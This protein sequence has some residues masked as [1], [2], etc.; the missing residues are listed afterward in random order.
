MITWSL[1]LYSPPGV[2][3][4]NMAVKVK[5]LWGMYIN[6]SIDR[7]P[8]VSQSQVSCLHNNIIIFNQ[9]KLIFRVM[10]FALVFQVFPLKCL[11]C[12][13]LPYAIPNQYFFS[14]S[15]VPGIALALWFPLVLTATH[16]SS[17]PSGYLKVRSTRP[18]LPSK[19]E[20]SVHEFSILKFLSS[21][22]FSSMASYLFVTFD[23]HQ[24]FVF[25]I[26]KLCDSSLLRCELVRHKW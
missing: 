17:S 21:H 20:K 2:S 4:C 22:N 7:I 13:N 3:S 14:F 8:K 19:L 16:S 18:G 25:N 9:F 23:F 10:R 1:H 15:A 24:F 12:I 26:F 5:A 6:S 11:M